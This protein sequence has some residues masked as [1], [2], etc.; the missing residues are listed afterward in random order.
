MKLEECKDS[1]VIK[2]LIYL[3][4]IYIKE[5]CAKTNGLIYKRI[6]VTGKDVHTKRLFIANA[7]KN[8]FDACD[9]D[10]ETANEGDVIEV[11]YVEKE[12]N[13]NI[14]HNFVNLRQNIHFNNNDT[15]QNERD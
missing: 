11:A 12:Y 3:K 14:Y 6:T 4:R 1:I 2:K 5:C 15:M 13:G 10:L 8:V 9:F 7:F